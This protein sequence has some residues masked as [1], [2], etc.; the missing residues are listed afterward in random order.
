MIS[1]TISKEQIH[2]KLQKKVGELVKHEGRMDKKVS[3]ILQIQ[4]TLRTLYDINRRKK[5]LGKVTIKLMKTKNKENLE[6]FQRGKKYYIYRAKN[7][8]FQ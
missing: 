7:T 8:S 4:K 2:M 6:H 5:K 3:K 1:R